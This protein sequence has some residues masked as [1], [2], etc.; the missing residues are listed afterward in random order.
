MR[1]VT[2]PQVPPDPSSPPLSPINLTLS[3]LHTLMD[4]T[5]TQGDA[6]GTARHSDS[7]FCSGERRTDSAN[8]SMQSPPISC[9]TTTSNITNQDESVSAKPIIGS[10]LKCRQSN[11]SHR[12]PLTHLTQG[13]RPVHHTLEQ[14]RGCKYDQIELSCSLSL[15]MLDL[16]VPRSV[17]AVSIDNA[18]KFTFNGS[19]FFSSV[20]LQ[21]GCVCVGDG[22]CVRLTQEGSAGLQELWR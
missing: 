4:T 3:Q 8:S 17:L 13:K 14:V 22:A 10:L 7:G 9:G 1:R 18:P 19:E 11:Q 2:S 12:L 5:L 20:A 16:G 6:P 21:R 15:Q